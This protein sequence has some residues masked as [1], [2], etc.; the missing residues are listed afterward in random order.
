MAHHQW[1]WTFSSLIWENNLALSSKVTETCITLAS[2]S[3]FHTFVGKFLFVNTKRLGQ[4][5]LLCQRPRNSLVISQREVN[6]QAD[7]LVGYLYNQESWPCLSISSTS[8]RI[9]K[10]RIENIGVGGGEVSVKTIPRVF[11]LILF[12][13]QN[14][15]LLFT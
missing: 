2:D 13:K 9:N 11:P 10:F 15:E 1:I 3:I 8:S 7:Q 4:D 12:L 5:F 6:R 14:R